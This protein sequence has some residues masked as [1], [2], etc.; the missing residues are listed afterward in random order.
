MVLLQ[1]WPGRLQVT[2][3]YH[4]LTVIMNQ[5]RFL[6]AKRTLNSE[7]G[8]RNINQNR[9]LPSRLLA[10]P[11][12]GQLGADN[13]DLTSPMIMTHNSRKKPRLLRSD[14]KANSNLP[15]GLIGPLY[16]ATVL[17]EGVQCESILYT[18]S[19]V[20]T[21][22]ETFHASYLSSLPIQPIQSA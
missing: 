6:Y 11:A 9:K 13:K 19:Q 21:I 22:S 18:G 14:S 3:Y 8:V 1:M 16:A 20:T 12:V 5:T 2:G 7:S 15:D 10:A 17:I 4:K